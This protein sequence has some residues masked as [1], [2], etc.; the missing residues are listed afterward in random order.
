MKE[1]GLSSGLR[2]KRH[3]LAPVVSL[4]PL[5]RMFFV[6]LGVHGHGVAVEE[7]R[8]TVVAETTYA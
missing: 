2:E 4:H 6:I 3:S 7:D 5:S 8:A 1:T